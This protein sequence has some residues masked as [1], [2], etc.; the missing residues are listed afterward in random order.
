MSIEMYDA[1]WKQ[2]GIVNSLFQYLLLHHE[3]MAIEIAL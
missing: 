2:F 3:S 1:I